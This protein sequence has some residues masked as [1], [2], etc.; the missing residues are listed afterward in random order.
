MGTVVDAGHRKRQSAV[1]C[2]VDAVETFSRGAVRLRLFVS[3]PRMRLMGE[4]VRMATEL[5]V[6][7][8]TPVLC[9][10]SVAR[11][12][13]Q[14]SVGHWRREAVAAA[15]Q[16]GNYFLPQLDRPISFAAAVEAAPAVGFVGAVPSSGSTPGEAGLLPQGQ[17]VGLW[18]GPEGGFCEDEELCLLRLGM[19]PLTVGQWVLRVETAV[20]ALLGQVI[21]IIGNDQLRCECR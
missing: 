14:Q 10:R 16:S 5:G 19:T 4:I 9:E 7:R 21:G 11:P 1:V 15:K 20:G 2:H 8:V 17:E 12:D 13:A 18:I 6:D 3:P